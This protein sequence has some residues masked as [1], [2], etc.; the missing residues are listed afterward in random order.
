MLFD[1]RLKGK[2]DRMSKLFQ[3][4]STPIEAT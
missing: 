1:I 4:I 3:A 2:D